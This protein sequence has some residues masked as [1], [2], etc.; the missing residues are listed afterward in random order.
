MLVLSFAALVEEASANTK[1]LSGNI[2][3]LA[4]L[5]QPE[6]LER[7]RPYAKAYCFIAFHASDQAVVDYVRGGTL[8]YDSGPDVLVLFVLDEPAPAAVQV[9]NGSLTA[10]VDL[11][12]GTHPAY[13]M[14]RDLF[15]STSVPPLPGL[16]LFEDLAE[17]REALYVPLGQFEDESKVRG[18]MR[19]TLSLVAHTATT[20]EPKKFLDDL[21]I[22]LFRHQIEFERTNRTP[23]REWLLRGLRA[24][25]ERFGDIVAGIGLGM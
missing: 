18:C 7:L 9:D 12:A 5:F 21:G 6:N 16:V 17:D 15:S 13:Q 1:N 23:L 11:S 3:D 22:A 19:Q 24:A 14:V 10:W 4:S 20:A 8:D 25:R 2:R